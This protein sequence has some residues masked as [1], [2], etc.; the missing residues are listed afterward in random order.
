[1]ATCDDARRCAHPRKGQ[2]HCAA[3]KE[4]ADDPEDLLVLQDS[5]KDAGHL[6][7]EDLDDIP[8]ILHPADTLSPVGMNE[9][10]EEHLTNTMH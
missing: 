5:L 10:N 9:T 7:G 4:G 3:A 8:L 6:Q 1:M 2:P